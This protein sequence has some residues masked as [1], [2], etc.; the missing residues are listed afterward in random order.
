MAQKKSNVTMRQVRER[1]LGC[2]EDETRQQEKTG[3]MRRWA[4]FTDKTWHEY[5][6]DWT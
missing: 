2:V 5:D 1:R 6:E 3:A 4:F